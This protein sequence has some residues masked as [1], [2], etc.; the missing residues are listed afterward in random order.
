M[1][2]T[3]EIEEGLEQLVGEIADGSCALQDFPFRLMEAYSA[4]RNEVARLC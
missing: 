4:S 1:L 3:I 2:N